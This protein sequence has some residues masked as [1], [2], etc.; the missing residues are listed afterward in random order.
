[1][2]A[3]LGRLKPALSQSGSQAQLEA[4]QQRVAELQKVLER[5]TEVAGEDGLNAL[6]TRVVAL[7]ESQHFLA[8]VINAL[9]DKSA[10][11]VGEVA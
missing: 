1:M 4:K 8:T 10:T 9:L 3:A 6:E 2:P 7:Q 5:V 11:V